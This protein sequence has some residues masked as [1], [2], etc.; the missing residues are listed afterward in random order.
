MAKKHVRLGTIANGEGENFSTVGIVVLGGT[1]ERDLDNNC[2]NKRSLVDIFRVSD[3]DDLGHWAIIIGS[4][5][6]IGG[7]ILVNKVDFMFGLGVAF[8]K[9]NILPEN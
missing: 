6:P 4:L 1:I 9:G 8:E 7:S 5:A 3:Y 2:S